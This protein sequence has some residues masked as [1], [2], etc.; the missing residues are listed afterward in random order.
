MTVRTPAWALLD[1]ELVLWERATLHASTHGFLYGTAVFE[2]VRAY[3][4]ESGGV[5]VFELAAHSDRLA[6]NARMMGFA[7]APDGTTLAG[8]TL[9]L[10]SALEAKED[11]YIRPVV[12]V[13]EGGIG[14]HPTTQ[15]TKTV[16]MAT[17]MQK[18]FSK[19]VLAAKVSS[20]MRISGRAIPPMGKINGA[21]ANS[22]LASKEAREA[23]FDEAILLNERGLVSEGSGENIWL[24]RDGELVT[25]GLDGDILDGITRRHV[26]DLA[27]DLGLVVHERGVPRSELY[28]ADE[29]FFSGTGVEIS[30]V[31]RVDHVTI[32]NGEPGPVTRAIHDR[33]HAS[34]R[35]LVPS[36]AR[37]L[38]P[39]VPGRQT[40]KT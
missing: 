27:R 39:V 14:I 15:K 40:K 29:I 2:G 35:G 22:Y 8:W 37:K 33:F 26:L 28:A 30:P 16:I 24:V 11:H 13:G 6:R 1:G 21:Y 5:A 17:P 3:K 18:Y 20:W 31:G 23:G 36:Y 12:Y 4:Q 7:G 34:I 9:D 32:G 19:G 25:P 38:T 10:L